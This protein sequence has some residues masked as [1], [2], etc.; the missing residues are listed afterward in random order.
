MIEKLSISLAIAALIAVATFLAPAWL[1]SLATVAA[2]TGL[3]V[4]GLLVL[5]RS[6]LVPFGQAL[7]FATGAYAV[8]L[9][10]QSG[11]TTDALLLLFLA[12]ASAGLLAFLVGFLIARYREIFFA[13]LSLAL[14]M[15]LYGTLV[16]SA[17]LGST[18][19]IHVGAATFLGAAPAGDRHIVVLFV[20]ASLLVASAAAGLNWYLGSVA[21]RL[22]SLV[23]QNEI[24]IEYMGF[25]VRTLV[26]AN[27]TI[28]G[29]LAGVGGGLTA[30]SIG[31]VDPSFA[32]WTTSGE[33]V[34]VTILAG[35]VSVTG[36]LLGS[37]LFVLFRSTAM[38]LIP[39]AWQLF[40]GS[41]LL[42][43][44]LFIPQGIGSLVSGS[45]RGRTRS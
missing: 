20:L 40:L 30:L 11:L 3:V 23:P 38:T 2:G 15:I 28:A 19:G 25:S 18:D 16:Q 12:A 22:T 31:H 29:A 4:L 1:L 24:R 7:Y 37:F 45:F 21:G 43:T 10:A 17:A 41:V 26:H 33:F 8:A 27:L 14:S 36:A 34:F 5:W 32:Y 35:T 9:A 42:L 39:E 13:M 44:I 6:G